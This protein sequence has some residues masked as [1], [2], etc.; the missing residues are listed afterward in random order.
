M[1]AQLSEE[2]I[3]GFIF[4]YLKQGWLSKVVEGSK[5]AGV[6]LPDKM[7]LGWIDKYLEEGQI[8]S[9]INAIKFLGLPPPKDRL[10]KA[11]RKCLH[12]VEL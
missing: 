4:Q 6:E 1:G 5:A 2:E 9:A 12:E 10:I 8:N 3:N 11:G 7:L